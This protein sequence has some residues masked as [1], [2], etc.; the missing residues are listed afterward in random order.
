[1]TKEREP[2]GMPLSWTVQ[3]GSDGQATERG[4]KDKEPGRP[5]ASAGEEVRP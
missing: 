1:M 5:E 2:R 4:D 3:Q